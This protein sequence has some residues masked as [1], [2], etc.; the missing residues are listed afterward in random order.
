MSLLALA[1]IVVILLTRLPLLLLD[2]P[3][4]GWESALSWGI[5]ALAAGLL[6]KGMEV[7]PWQCLALGGGHALLHAGWWGLERRR[8]ADVQTLRLATAIPLLMLAILLGSPWTGFTLRDHSSW[9]AVSASAFSPLGLL[10]QAPWRAILAATAGL[11]LCMN[12]ANA[13]IRWCQATRKLTHQATRKLTPWL[14]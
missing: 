7:H 13:L 6:T 1:L 3:V 10:V 5:Q 2:R 11:L 4:K 9:L 14:M 8:D 12:E